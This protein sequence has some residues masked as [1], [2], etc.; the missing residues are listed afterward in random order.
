MSKK[1]FVLDTNVLLHSANAIHSFGD[2]TVVISFTV[3]EELDKLKKGRTD[4]ISKNARE[5]IRFMDSL[6]EKG[7]LSKG[8]AM[9]N[10]GVLQIFANHQKQIRTEMRNLNLDPDVPDNRIIA[11]ASFL[12]GRF[13]DKEVVLVSQDINVRLKADALGLSVGEYYGENICVKNDEAYLGYREVEV[14]K[15]DINLFYSKGTLSLKKT[16]LY[17]N[18]FVIIVSKENSKSSAIGRAKSKDTIVRVNLLDMVYGV[19][20]RNKEQKMAV[21]LLLD[22][23]VKVVSLSGVAG[24]GKTLLAVACALEQVINEQRF[25]KIIVARPIIPLGKD[26][27]Y[28]PGDKD[29]K[30]FS[31]MQ[32]IFD[33]L[34]FLLKKHNH[35]NSK[36][37]GETLGSKMGKKDR[38]IAKGVDDDLL[39]AKGLMS[40]GLLEMEALTYMRGRTVSNTIIIIDEAQNLTPAEVKTVCTRCGEGSKIILTGDPDQIDNPY[41][42]SASNGLSVMVERMKDVIFYAHTSLRTSERSEV[43]RI[44]SQRM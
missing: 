8:V 4:E 35:T 11:T 16:E 15:K 42:G 41:L 30:L 23:A 28:L 9:P 22:P 36:G 13:P 2:N 43:A 12:K 6:R 3:L 19:S 7:K 18:E 27:G 17:P 37:F 38:N 33:N 44:F 5:A 21:N 1:I 14:L 20:L 31:W 25:E 40:R 32:P 34:E 39:T 26:I 29:E 10:G 24:T